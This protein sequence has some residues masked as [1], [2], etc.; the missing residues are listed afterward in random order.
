MGWYHTNGLTNPAPENILNILSTLNHPIANECIKKVC[1]I[2]PKKVN[3]KNEFGETPLMLSV[4]S[5]ETAKNDFE[6]LCCINNINVLLA[7]GADVNILDDNKQNVLHR[8]CQSNCLILL[9]KFLEK[10][11][12][13]NQKDVLGKNPLEYLSKEITNKMRNYFE[14]YAR[15]KGITLGIEN[16]LKGIKK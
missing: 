11:V 8:V 9:S 13:I 10:D 2:F 15:E 7:N 14:N 6:K 1:E 4:D 5:Y 12:N 3:L 16:I